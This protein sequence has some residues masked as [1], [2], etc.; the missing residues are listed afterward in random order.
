VVH[1]G[2]KCEPGCLPVFSV[3]TEAEAK[4]LLVMACPRGLDGQYYARE[5]AREQTL[6][7]LEA[8]SDRLQRCYTL[9]K[10]QR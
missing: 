8:F 5:L 1:F 2:P 9:M 7:G 6:E 10:E 3:E 4:Q